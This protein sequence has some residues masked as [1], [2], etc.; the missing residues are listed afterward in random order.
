M[1]FTEK[2]A[3]QIAP[4]AVHVLM[5]IPAFGDLGKSA[6][7]VCQLGEYSKTPLCQVQCLVLT[8]G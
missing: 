2:A 6:N 3:E 4:S 5:P 1:S 8:K 7:D